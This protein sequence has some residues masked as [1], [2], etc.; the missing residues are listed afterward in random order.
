MPKKLDELLGA[1][2]PTQAK[3]KNLNPARQMKANSG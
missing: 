1:I 3:I 2:S